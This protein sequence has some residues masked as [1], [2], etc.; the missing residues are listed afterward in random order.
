MNRD[1]ALIICKVSKH[2]YYYTETGKSPGVGSTAFTPQLQD[3]GSWVMVSEK[4]I[5]AEVSEIKQVPETDYGYK[6]MC[7]ALMLKGYF[8]NHKKVYRIMND[9]H[10]LHERRKRPSRIYA[11]YRKVYPT[12]P[13]EVIEMDIKYQWVDQHAQHAYILTILD[14]F[15]RVVL[16]WEV[17]YTMQQAQI[18]RAWEQVIINH[19]QEHNTL[20]KGIHIEIRTDNGSQFASKMIQQFFKDNYLNQVF[21]HPYTPQENGHIESFHAILG[22]SLG[23]KRFFKIDDLERYL[24]TFYQI[25]NYERLHSSVASFCPMT[26]WKLWKQNLIEVKEMKNKSLTFKPKVPYYQLTGNG[27]MR[28]TSCT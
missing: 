21:T 23:K 24:M 10:L 26:F 16:H 19:L 5:I 1:K 9:N 20:S 28:S 3:D 27:N 15:T 13:L 22:E 12:Q 17:G 11:K 2:Q 7:V 25:Y 8:I 18:K 14:T 4:V 6:K